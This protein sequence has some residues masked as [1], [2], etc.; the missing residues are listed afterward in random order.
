MPQS[1]VCSSFVKLIGILFIFA[2]LSCGQRPIHTIP[3]SPVVAGPTAEDLDEDGNMSDV[4]PGDE[5]DNV[6]PAIVQAEPQPDLTRAPHPFIKL[7]DRELSE[8]YRKDK[9][10]LG[11]VSVGQPAGG[12]LIGG[13]PMPENDAWHIVNPKETWGT[14]ETIDFLSTN[15]RAVYDRF[16]NTRQLPIGDI[17]D[18]DGGYLRPHLSH[19][20]GRDVDV[21]YYYAN[22]ARWYTKVTK[23]NLDF[24]RTWA[25]VRSIITESDIHAIFMDTAVQRMLKEYALSIGEDAEWLDK[26]FGGPLSNLRPIISHEPGHRS[27]L[28][29]RYYNPI[30]QETGRRLH[31]ILVKEKAI[32]PRTSYVSYKVKRGDNLNKIAKRFKTTVK[33]LK[34]ANRL[35]SNRIIANRTYKIPRKGGVAKQP[36]VTRIPARRLPPTNPKQAR[37]KAKPKTVEVK[38]VSATVEK[39]PIAKPVD[40][41]AAPSSAPAP[42]PESNDL[43]PKQSDAPAVSI[44]GGDAPDSDNVTPVVPVPGNDT[45]ADNTPPVPDLPTASILE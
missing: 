18:Q 29:L 1:V 19:Q 12:K 17:S 42:T 40:V 27:H 24:P 21:A 5:G 4:G 28:H 3:P 14:Q 16:P 31:A 30:A 26:I 2:L 45:P 6:G 41:P 37:T 11:S 15:I 13:V 8:L 39:L 35:K 23:E 33:A 36:R 22:G 20:S 7:S 25:F 10:A 9:K 34:R 32:L 38:P 44:P 43:A